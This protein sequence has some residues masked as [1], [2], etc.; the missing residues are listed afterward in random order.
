MYLSTEWLCCAAWPAGVW[1]PSE[2]SQ[3]C[4]F[5]TIVALNQLTR[6]AK[7]CCI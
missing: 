5:E 2:R 7:R 1:L 4:S 3:V 6:P